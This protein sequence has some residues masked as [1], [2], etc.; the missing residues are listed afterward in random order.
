MGAITEPPAIL[1]EMIGSALVG[2]FL[3]VF[4]AYEAWSGPMAARTLAAVIEEEGILLQDHPIGAGGPPARQR[5]PDLRGDRPRQR[6]LRAPNQPSFLGTGRSPVGRSRP[7]ARPWPRAPARSRG[8]GTRDCRD[9]EAAHS[10]GHA[11][12]RRASPCRPAR[13]RF[14]NTETGSASCWSRRRRC[15]GPLSIAA[16]GKPRLTRPPTPPTPAGRRHEFRRRRERD[17]ATAQSAAAT[18]AADAAADANKAEAATAPPRPRP[19]CRA[20]AA[21]AKK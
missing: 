6:A 17:D 13:N 15:R 12:G 7:R 5:R 19:P 18:A 9:G 10:L 2:T 1:G 4:L 8:S 21:P 11:P 14:M 20:P 3:G 16:C